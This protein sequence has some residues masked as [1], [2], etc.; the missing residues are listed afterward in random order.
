MTELMGMFVSITPGSMIVWSNISIS[1]MLA[2]TAKNPIRIQTTRSSINIILRL[3]I[4]NL[5]LK[6]AR[7]RFVGLK[8]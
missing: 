3:I 7:I 1:S 6:F 5:K 2:P 4:D 8:R